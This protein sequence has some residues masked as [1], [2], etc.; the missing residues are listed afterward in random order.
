M[1]NQF[2][3]IHIG[4]GSPMFPKNSELFQFKQF[5]K[6]L[7]TRVEAEKILFQRLFRAPIGPIR[8]VRN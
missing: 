3:E 4:L 1:G 7:K 2:S 8:L 5:Q 6:P